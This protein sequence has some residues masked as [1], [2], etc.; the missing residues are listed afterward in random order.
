V[1]AA[2][3]FEWTFCRALIALSKRPNVDVRQSLSHVYGLDK[4]KELWWDEIKDRPRALHLP[5]VLRNWDGVKRAFDER[6]RLIHGRNRH[7]RNMA[8]PHVEVLLSA[9]AD[10]NHFCRSCEVDLNQ[11]L[12]VR[13][14]SRANASGPHNSKG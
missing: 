4:Y 2:V 12:P 3:Y 9:V 8:T 11:R 14:R 6:N 1:V 5:E 13:K 10:L 7:T